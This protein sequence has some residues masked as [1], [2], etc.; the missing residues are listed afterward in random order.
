MDCLMC[1][2]TLAIAPPRGVLHKGMERIG[3]CDRL[4]TTR[5]ETVDILRRALAPK[6]TPASASACSPAVPK[7]LTGMW[8]GFYALPSHYWLTVRSVVC[9]VCRIL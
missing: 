6:V 4:R 9:C 8:L 7:A 2:R 3:P 5:A 1:S